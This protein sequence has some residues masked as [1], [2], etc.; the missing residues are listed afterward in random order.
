M[1]SPRLGSTPQTWTII[2]YLKTDRP[3]A[4]SSAGAQC[5]SRASASSQDVHLLFCKLGAPA[6]S[7]W[8]DDWPSTCHV[9]LT[10]YLSNLASAIVFG[11]QYTSSK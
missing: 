9:A 6:L 2:K 8:S 1:A 3:V 10:T 11:E 4:E 5:A 7:C